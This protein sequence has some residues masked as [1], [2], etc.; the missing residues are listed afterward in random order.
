[1]ISRRHPAALAL[2]AAAVLAVAGCSGGGGSDIEVARVG[3]ATVTEVVEAPATVTARASATV[4]SPADGSVAELR[5]QEGQQVRAGQVLL[6]VESPAARRALRQ[7]KKADAR[8]ASAATSGGGPVTLAGAARA[9]AQAS[10]AFARA[11]R[12]AQRIPD[13]A[14]RRQALSALQ[15]SQSQYRAAR[16]AA[17]RAAAQLAAGL[18]SLSDAVAALSSAQR[19]QTRAAVAVAKQ[20]VAALVVR[21]PV[22]GTV[23]L[24]PPAGAASGSLDASAL[25]GQLPESLQGQAGSLLGGSGPT[26]SVDAVLAEGRP[27]SRGQG[28]LTVT[29]ASQLSLTAQVDETD[30]L[31]VTPGVPASA[32][33]DAVP[34]ATYESSVTS[35][36]PTPS[37]SSRGG[38]T[39]VVRLSL[40]RGM[41]AAG[42]AAPTPRPGMSAVVDL[43]VRTARD[44][45]AVPAAAVFR[46]GRRDAVWVVLNGRARERQVRLGAQGESRVQ[47]VEGLKIGEHV[48]VR[49]ADQVRAGDEVP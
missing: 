20:S 3:R 35:I 15:V 12:A 42:A 21:S 45:V 32:E 36:D 29:D 39:Y 41:S 37:Q 26:S 27:V 30:V 43:D 47:V 18:G 16:S 49:G 10:R 38:V 28:L 46:D 8:A 31:L 11:R 2:T 13:P 7:A 4:S 23:S 25:V 6:R 22:D 48:V 9:D 33:L 44:T 1:M 14:A 19:V 24:S 5:V 34:D 17:D 40:G